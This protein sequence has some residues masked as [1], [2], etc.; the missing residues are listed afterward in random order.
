MDVI[1]TI[2]IGVNAALQRHFGGAHV[3]RFFGALSNVF[4][5]EQ[6]WRAAQIEREWAF[7]ETTE[8]ALERAHIGVIDI[9]VVHPRDNITHCFKA[10]FV[11]YASNRS[12]LWASGSKQIHD[13]L[14]VDAMA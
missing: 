7:R 10:Q 5:R 1:V 13:F 4:Q 6:V 11:G 9:A 8:L 12:N 3:P 14:F 2:E